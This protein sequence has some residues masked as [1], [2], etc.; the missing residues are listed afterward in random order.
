MHRKREDAPGAKSFREAFHLELLAE[1]SPAGQLDLRWNLRIQS[2]LQV[3]SSREPNRQKK[4]QLGVENLLLE[5]VPISQERAQGPSPWEREVA[6]G[7]WGSDHA[8][9]PT[10]RGR[11]SEPSNAGSEIQSPLKIIVED[12][13]CSESELMKTNPILRNRRLK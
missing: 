2:R 5:L 6:S 3:D 9:R 7:I 13:N 10:N 8:S 4:G 12:L 1:N 11:E